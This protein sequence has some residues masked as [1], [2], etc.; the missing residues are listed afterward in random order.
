MSKFET[1]NALLGIFGLEFENKHLQICL[2]AKFRKRK[3]KKKPKFT[4]KNALF[5]Y[6]RARIWKSY[7]PIWNQHPQICLIA[8]F[9][10]K[11]QKCL[12]FGPKMTYLGIFGLTF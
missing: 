5:G 1:K 11:K 8:K 3:T 2:I 7:F 6:C 12:N 9:R 4:S 10:K